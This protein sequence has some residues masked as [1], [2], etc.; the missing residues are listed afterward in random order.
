MPSI[1]F[2]EVSHGAVAYLFG[3]D[4]AKRAGRL[5]L[6]PLR[7]VDPIGTIVVPAIT[8][9][10]GYGFFGWAKPVP[11]DV[12]RLRHPRNQSV[13]VSLAGPFTNVVL[14]AICGLA[15]HVFYIASATTSQTLSLP[16][17]VL[18]FAGAVNLW[19]AIFNMVPI[20]PLDGSALI[21]R[22]LPRR[23]WPA[24]M[25]LRSRGMFLVFALILLLAL[26][27]VNPL[28][29]VFNHVINWYATL[30]SK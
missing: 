24:Y 10:S 3:D 21:E 7:H 18:L 4:T 20:P 1:I 14:A 27:N 12:R 30:I 29:P 13:F 2:H 16:A 22:V 9:L 23:L 8:V 11:V 15:F 26:I 25:R 17:R 6:N 28:A 5:S 19:V